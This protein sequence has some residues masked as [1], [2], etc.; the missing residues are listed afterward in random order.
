MVAK[1][2]FNGAEIERSNDIEA[3]HQPGEI[4][5]RRKASANQR[6]RNGVMASWHRRSQRKCGVMAAKWQLCGEE[7]AARKRK[8][9]LAA[10]SALASAANQR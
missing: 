8:L 5:Q 9:S 10:Q 6:R 1:M 4:W 3:W 7:M 2:A